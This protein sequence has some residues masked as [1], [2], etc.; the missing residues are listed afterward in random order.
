[1]DIL[2]AIYQLIGAPY[3]CCEKLAL[4]LLL[5]NATLRGD[6]SSHRT[7][8]TYQ[9]FMDGLCLL[10]DDLIDSHNHLLNL[11]QERSGWVLFQHCCSQ[12]WDSL[13]FLLM[14]NSATSVSLLPGRDE[15]HLRLLSH[16]ERRHRWMSSLPTRELQGSSCRSP[17]SPIGDN[18]K[19]WRLFFSKS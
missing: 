5:H 14:G 4:W 1:M 3:H 8:R 19:K 9:W 16:I 6:V 10:A 18:F 15:I 12:G 2:T 11:L 7:S 17:L 13:L